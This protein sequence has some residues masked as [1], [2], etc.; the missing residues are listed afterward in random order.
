MTEQD[1]KLFQNILDL[2]NTLIERIDFL[3]KR[4]EQLEAQVRMA[5]EE[6]R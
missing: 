6:A 2:S 4:V 5:K 3:Q 1:L